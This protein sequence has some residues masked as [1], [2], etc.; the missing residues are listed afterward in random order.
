MVPISI[1]I[2]K[3]VLAVEVEVAADVVALDDTNAEEFIV[4]RNAAKAAIKEL[5]AEKKAVDEALRAL[6]GEATVGTLNG[7][8]RVRILPRQ[9]EGIDSDLLKESFI[10]AYEATRKVTAYTILDAK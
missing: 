3:R 10:E 2:E 5:E 7:T 6:L 1:K 9:R 8:D 4:R